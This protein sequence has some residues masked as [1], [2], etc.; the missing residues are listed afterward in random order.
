[1]CVCVFSIV[2]PLIQSM[3]THQV[4]AGKYT[5]T[6]IEA[7]LLSWTMAGATMILRPIINCLLK[8]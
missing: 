5:L 7:L 4:P 1:M 6:E 3:Y 8:R 2:K